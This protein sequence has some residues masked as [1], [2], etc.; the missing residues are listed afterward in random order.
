MTGEKKEKN[1]LSQ[2]RYPGFPTQGIYY[3]IFSGFFGHRNGAK[4]IMIPRPLLS[5]DVAGFEQGSLANTG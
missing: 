2:K 4:G 1:R 3:T 5:P